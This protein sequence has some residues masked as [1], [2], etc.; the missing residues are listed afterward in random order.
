MQL[1]EEVRESG[2]RAESGFLASKEE[3][4]SSVELRE[5]VSSIGHWTEVGMAKASESGAA[6]QCGEATTP[7]AMAVTQTRATKATMAIAQ[8]TEASV[9]EAMASVEVSEVAHAVRR[10]GFMWVSRMSFPSVPVTNFSGTYIPP[11]M[12]GANHKDFHNFHCKE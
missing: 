8:A 1:K 9:A 10:C 3:A 4:H 7:T 2:S 12:G 11:V 5:P 6:A